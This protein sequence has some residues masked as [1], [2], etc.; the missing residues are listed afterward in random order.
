L[1]AINQTPTGAAAPNEV[2]VANNQVR[3]IVN[4]GTSET[5]FGT[6]FGNT[7]RNVAQDAISNIGSVSVFKQIKFSE[8]VGF[9]VHATA[10]NVFNHPNFFSVDP[11][12][13]DAGLQLQFT[14]FGDPTLTNSQP[15]RLILGAKLSF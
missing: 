8:R 4:S 12:V 6:P 1:N 14:G 9:S 10:I 3:Y 2:T 13:E 7:P 15:R 5:V 11:F